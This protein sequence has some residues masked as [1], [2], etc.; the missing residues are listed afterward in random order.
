M[1]F[2]IWIGKTNLLIKV[3]STRAKNAP[4]KLTRA[5]IKIMNYTSF[6]NQR[7][8]LGNL[9]I[10]VRKDDRKEVLRGCTYNRVISFIGK[11]KHLYEIYFY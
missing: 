1:L 11:N 8:R 5:K 9:Y 2:T 3:K 4:F 7:N 6:M 10:I